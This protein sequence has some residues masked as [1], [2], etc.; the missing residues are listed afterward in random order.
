MWPLERYLR[1]HIKKLNRRKGCTVILG[2]DSD[3]E[4]PIVPNPQEICIGVI[5]EKPKSSIYVTTQRF[6]YC[7]QFN[8]WISVFFSNILRCSW[9]PNDLAMRWRRKTWFPRTDEEYVLAKE[10]MVAQA[11]IEE[12]DGTVHVFDQEIRRN[13]PK[14]VEDIQK[15]L[16]KHSS[17]SRGS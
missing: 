1:V 13:L 4:W 8:G 15:R 2:A 6:I 14:L 5:H 11:V 10:G 17:E 16:H 3:V 9:K 7:H 12:Q